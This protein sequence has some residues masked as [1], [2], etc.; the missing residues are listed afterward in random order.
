[1]EVVNYECHDARLA[2]ESLSSQGFW[3]DN[4]LSVCRTG[5]SLGLPEEAIVTRLEGSGF[6]WYDTGTPY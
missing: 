3:I 5:E 1:M 4:M 6:Y 2:I